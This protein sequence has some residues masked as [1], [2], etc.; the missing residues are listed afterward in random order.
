MAL[1]LFG[2]ALFCCTPRASAQD[3]PRIVI[4]VPFEFVVNGKTMPAGRYRVQKPLP[5]SDCV[6]YI[7]K[8]GGNEGTSFATNAAVDI[9]APNK[10]A[11]IFHHYGSQHYLAEVLTGSNNTGYRLPVSNEE[12]AAARGDKSGDKS[13]ESKSG[14]AR[15]ASQPEKVAAGDKSK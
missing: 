5:D 6:F 7:S 9:S 4:D 13:N 10:A 15:T 11:L 1:I 3:L 8:E 2:A 14:T 12:R